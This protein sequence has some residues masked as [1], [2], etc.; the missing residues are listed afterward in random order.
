MKTDNEM[1]KGVQQKELEILCAFKEIC[2]KY[3]LKY[4]L[5][6]GTLL[7]AVRHKG[8]IPWDDDVDVCMPIADYNLFL[9]IGQRELGD[10]YFIQNQM[11]EINFPSPFSKIRLNDST[12][13]D[14][15]Y[16]QWH[17]NHGIWIDI[18]PLVD[19]C[20]QKK[21]YKRF[22]LKICRVLQE[23]DLVACNEDIFKQLYGTKTVRL[24]KALYG[25]MPLRKRQKL[26]TSLLRSIC[27]S[28]GSGILYELYGRLDYAL[29][30]DLFKKKKQ[31][32]FEGITFDV[33]EDYDSYLKIY[34]GDYMTLPPEEKREPIHADIIDLN[35]SY[36]AINASV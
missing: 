36:E 21:R 25:I 26:H 14:S 11:T 8:F 23:D 4:F 33:P 34:Y 5:S 19:V 29:P 18:F 24:L 28:D 3:N 1:L 6:S 20:D 12:F 2:E 31:L 13:L 16:S 17:I 22:I 30:E 27:E 35:N 7:G 15:K 10:K 9:Q 32:V